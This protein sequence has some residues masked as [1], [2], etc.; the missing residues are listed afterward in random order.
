METAFRAPA[1]LIA[2][3]NKRGPPTRVLLTSSRMYDHPAERASRQPLYA[4]ALVCP[5]LGPNK[6]V[7]DRREDI[8]LRRHERY[9][10]CAVLCEGVT[11]MYESCLDDFLL[12]VR[13]GQAVLRD[14]RGEAGRAEGG[15]KG[16]VEPR[17]EASVYGGGERSA[18]GGTRA[19]TEE[20][21]VV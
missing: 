4:L 1:R 12:A 21:R 20:K 6:D 2:L 16:D 11:R 14:A 13:G 9:L 15:Q 10:L 18:S 19:R 7:R 5:C 3:E 17:V 8:V